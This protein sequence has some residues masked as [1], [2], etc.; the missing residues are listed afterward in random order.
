MYGLYFPCPS[1]APK[2]DGTSEGHRFQQ[3]PHSS[4]RLQR[5][6]WVPRG[7]SPGEPGP[8]KHRR[9]PG[10]MPQGSFSSLSLQFVQST[11]PQTGWARWGCPGGAQGGCGWAPW[12]RKEPTEQQK[13]R[14]WARL[15]INTSKTLEIRREML[16]GAQ[17]G[18]AMFATV[19]KAALRLERRAAWKGGGGG[20]NSF[21]K[22]LSMCSLSNP[23]EFSLSQGVNYSGSYFNDI[24]PF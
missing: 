10:L 22:P 24:L 7:G 4:Q 5:D 19:Q 12:A 2:I 8:P 3:E 18:K 6:W 14:C 17:G 13:Q 15:G 16:S 1:H 21:L 20:G 23:F 9:S 11:P